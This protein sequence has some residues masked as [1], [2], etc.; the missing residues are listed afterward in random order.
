MCHPSPFVNLPTFRGSG[1][2]AWHGGGV[3]F[4]GSGPRAP[5]PPVIPG[6]LLGATVED[7]VDKEPGVF[8]PGDRVYLAGVWS[9]E[10]RVRAVTPAGV[11]VVPE[12]GCGGPSVLPADR[13]VHAAH[14]VT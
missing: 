13:L 8:A 1:A 14:R 7:A 5:L 11:E 4:P 9:R 10:Y 12:C 6:D 3:S 2:D